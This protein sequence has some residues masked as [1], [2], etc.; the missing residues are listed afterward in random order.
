MLNDHFGDGFARDDHD[1][2][3][4]LTRD[5]VPAVLP[6]TIMLAIILAAYV[7]MVRFPVSYILVVGEDRLGE[8]GTA[9]AFGLAALVFLVAALRTDGFVRVSGLLLAA[10]CFLIGGEEISWGQ[11]IFNVGTPEFLAGINHQ[12]EITLHNIG[13]AQFAPFH[14]VAGTGMLALALVTA[15][16]GLLGRL[17]GL[18]PIPSRPLWAVFAIAAVMLLVRPFAKGDE[19]AE[20]I[21]SLAVLFWACDWFAADQGRPARGVSMAA[22][23]VVAVAATGLNVLFADRNKA[24]L[25]WRY[26]TLAMRDFPALGLYPQSHEILD[27]LVAQN[28]VEGDLSEEREALR[29]AAAAD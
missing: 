16:P 2:E 14:A 10:A 18:V 29:L 26:E 25:V 9:A 8:F 13:S 1:A 3:T 11:R 7:V 20:L 19:L 28:L 17:A 15:F 24:A 6:T 12:N 23:L 4:G 21:L 5:L 22:L 27:Y